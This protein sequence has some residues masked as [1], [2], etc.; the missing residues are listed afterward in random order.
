MKQFLF[1]P[2][3]EENEENFMLSME[4]ENAINEIEELFT[5]AE[6]IKPSEGFTSRFFEKLEIE[7]KRIYRRQIAGLLGFN[8][9]FILVIAGFLFTNLNF[10][11]SNMMAVLQVFFE[12]FFVL[13]D[14]KNPNIS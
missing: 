13:F 7:K 1:E 14:C 3:I 12:Q 10:Q 2:E 8:L 6:M 4:M 11:L 5:S 9:L